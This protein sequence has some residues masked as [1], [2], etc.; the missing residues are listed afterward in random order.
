MTLAAR[1]IRLVMQLRSAGISDTDVLSAIERIPRDANGVTMGCDD[2]RN[3]RGP[4][5]GHTFRS[6]AH[7]TLDLA[8]GSRRQDAAIT[9]C[10]RRNDPLL[11]V[12][13][14]DA[15]AEKHGVGRFAVLSDDGSR[16]DRDENRRGQSADTT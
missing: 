14:D 7:E 5:Q 1:K 16:P 3:D 15:A 10:E 2:P 13:R 9:N 8:I 6:F 4:L 12:H 11:R